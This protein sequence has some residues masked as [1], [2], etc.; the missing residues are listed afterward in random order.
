MANFEEDSVR[1]KARLDFL[2]T[3]YKT[4]WDNINRHVTVM[5]QSVAVL[6]SAFAASFFLKG[7]ILEGRGPAVDVIASL[8]VVACMWVIAHAYDAGLWCN[9]NLQIIGNI[10]RELL[11]PADAVRI[12]PFVGGRRKNE[13][14]GYFQIQVVLAVS[15]AGFAM[16]GHFHSRVRDQLSPDN[17][18]DPIKIL[19]YAVLVAGAGW[20]WW[21]RRSTRRSFDRFVAG[22]EEI[23]R[24]AEGG[25]GGGG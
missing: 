14:L 2:A 10:E 7:G 5:W 22:P 8:V 13:L 25:P 21:V 20:V 9:R 17:P 16:V 3:M 19:P 15:L 12:H 23:P 1:A 18:I 11:D 24:E 4:M 6:A